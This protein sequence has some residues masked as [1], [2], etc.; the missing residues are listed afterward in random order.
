L[1]DDEQRNEFYQLRRRENK[2]TDFTYP[3]LTCTISESD[4]MPPEPIGN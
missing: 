4:L 3:Q 2:E 1:A